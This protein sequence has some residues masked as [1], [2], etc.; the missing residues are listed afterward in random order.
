MVVQLCL[1]KEVYDKGRVAI[2]VLGIFNNEE[3]SVFCFD[4]DNQPY[5]TGNIFVLISCQ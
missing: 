2:R 3:G 1:G 5:S 4:R